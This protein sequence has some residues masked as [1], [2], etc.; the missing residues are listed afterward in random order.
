MK[1]S[2]PISSDR[3]I[4]SRR[5][6]PGG[7]LRAPIRANA[8]KSMLRGKTLI[9]GVGAPKSGT[10]WLHSY[11]KGD[12]RVAVSPIKELHFFD[13][14]LGTGRQQRWKRRFV[15]RLLKFVLESKGGRPLVKPLARRV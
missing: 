6:R 13:D 3:P 11:L 12:A 4:L 15:Q 9:L 1:Q 2:S 14:W 8:A 5:Q 10:S 7:P